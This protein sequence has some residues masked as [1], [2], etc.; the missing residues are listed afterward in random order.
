MSAFVSS[1]RTFS[2]KESPSTRS[3]EHR[4]LYS[5]V[6]LA[7]LYS[8]AGSEERSAALLTSEMFEIEIPPDEADSR[9]D[10]RGRERVT[11]THNG[12]KYV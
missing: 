5:D 6:L 1:S 8:G 11:F 9:S 10:L 2:R 3:S 12:R 7:S 4:L